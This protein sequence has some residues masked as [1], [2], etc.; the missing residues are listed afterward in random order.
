MKK[1]IIIAVSL[2]TLSACSKSGKTTSTTPTSSY[3]I[4]LNGHSYHRS[5]S[6]KITPIVV[7]GIAATPGDCQ[8]Q[9]GINDPGYTSA[10]FWGSKA[11][12]TN[13]VGTYNVI[14]NSAN[15]VEDYGDQSILYVLSGIN[16][17]TTYNVG[18][19]TVSVYN[20]TEIKGT[21]NINGVTGND[22]LI[23]NITGDFDYNF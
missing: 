15:D 1:L 22:T 5:S 19:I 18:T 20:S 23:H 6:S 11:D 10:S 12:T 9:I 3:D 17:A 13:K 21:F 2:L 16:G 14:G 4:T 7:I 8:V